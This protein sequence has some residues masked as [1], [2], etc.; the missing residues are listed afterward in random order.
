MKTNLITFN[1]LDFNE[2]AKLKKDYIYAF[3]SV[4]S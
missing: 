2:V 4:V 1:G 3:I